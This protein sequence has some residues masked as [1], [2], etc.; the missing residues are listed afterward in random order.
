[1]SLGVRETR[2]LSGPGEMGAAVGPIC[3]IVED[4]ALIGLSL[5]AYLEEVGFGICE[6]VPSSKDALEWLVSNTPTIVILDY[7]LRDGPCT[8]LAR[9]LRERGIPFL[10]YSG[11][12]RSVAPPELQDVPWLHKPCDRRALLAALSPAGSVFARS[13]T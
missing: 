2:A 5:E 13:N 7:S 4:Q 12:R 10:I 11:H 3:L 9:T 8:A 1:M 6:V